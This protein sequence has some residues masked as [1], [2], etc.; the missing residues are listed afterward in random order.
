MGFG[1]ASIPSGEISSFFGIG[2]HVAWLYFRVDGM[3]ISTEYEDGQG[4]DKEVSFTSWLYSG[5]P[6]ELRTGYQ[7][8]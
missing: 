8:I 4:C 5:Q 2:Q 6:M 3:G 7:S 1:V